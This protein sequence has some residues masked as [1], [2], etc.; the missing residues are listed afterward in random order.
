MPPPRLNP[1]MLL[2]FVRAQNTNGE[3][4]LKLSDGETLSV[5]DG[6]SKFDKEYYYSDI[7]EVKEYIVPESLQCA[8]SNLTGQFGMGE[9]VTFIFSICAK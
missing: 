7:Y 1:A 5:E 3:I 4:E 2:R 9:A 6:D 8:F